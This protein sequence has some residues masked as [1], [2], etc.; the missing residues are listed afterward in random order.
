MRI[1]FP[2]ER[3]LA[4]ILLRLHKLNNSDAERI[5]SKYQISFEKNTVFIKPHLLKRP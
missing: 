1:C 4:S 5:F 3:Y 2:K